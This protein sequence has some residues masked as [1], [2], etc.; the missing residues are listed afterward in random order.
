[1]KTFTTALQYIIWLFLVEDT[2]HYSKE[3]TSNLGDTLGIA[4]KFRISYRI[5]EL[6]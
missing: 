4:L 1:M 2:T 5:L 6:G 3:H